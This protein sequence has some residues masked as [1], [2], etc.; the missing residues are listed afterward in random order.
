MQQESRLT[1]TGG[2]RARLA[3]RLLIAAFA[4]ALHSA[5]AAA[6]P[7]VGAPLRNPRLESLQI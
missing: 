7:A 5:L 4:L 1:G 3:S 6:A 2:A